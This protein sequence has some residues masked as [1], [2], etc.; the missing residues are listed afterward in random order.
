MYTYYVRFSVY[1]PKMKLCSIG[2]TDVRCS[3][4][5]TS[6]DEIHRI[7][8][9]LRNKIHSKNIVVIDYYTLLRKD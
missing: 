9:G 5:I 3:E 4:P 8:K 1:T 2:D 7:V 6:I